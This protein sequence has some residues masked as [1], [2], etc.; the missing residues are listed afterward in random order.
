[1]RCVNENQPTILSGT[2]GIDL[3][4]EHMWNPQL[5]IYI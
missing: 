1:M 2:V 4:M 5:C 3:L